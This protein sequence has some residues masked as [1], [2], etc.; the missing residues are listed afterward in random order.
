MIEEA[1][2]E[3]SVATAGKQ[4]RRGGR[5]WRTI[6]TSNFRVLAGGIVAGNSRKPS[7]AKCG[8]LLALGWSGGAESCKRQ[9]EESTAQSTAKLSEQGRN[10]EPTAE[11]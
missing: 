9:A 6:P 5:P 7:T 8:R 1:A 4:A 11:V 10:H 2:E 3:E